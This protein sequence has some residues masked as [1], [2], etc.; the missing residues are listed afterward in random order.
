MGTERFGSEAAGGR[1]GALLRVDDDAELEAGG[2]VQGG[3]PANR[4][5]ISARKRLH[6]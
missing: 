4:V 3:G 2:M 6:F 5:V 1:E